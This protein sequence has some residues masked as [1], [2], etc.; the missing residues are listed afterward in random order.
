M[1]EKQW[2]KESVIPSATVLIVKMGQI[3]KI[4]AFYYI[5]KGNYKAKFKKK[6]FK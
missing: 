6:K 1:E 3:W 4:S 5:I 2:T